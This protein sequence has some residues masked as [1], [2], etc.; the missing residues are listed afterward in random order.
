[1]KKWHKMPKSDLSQC[2]F[3]KGRLFLIRPQDEVIVI[4]MPIS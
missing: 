4:L 2:V 3:L 1:M